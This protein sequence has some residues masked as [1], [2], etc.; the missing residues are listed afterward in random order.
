VGE[1]GL[2]PEPGGGQ[3]FGLSHG[4]AAEE[5]DNTALNRECDPAVD[6]LTNFL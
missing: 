5:L 4:G 1:G 6:D 2:F 3:G